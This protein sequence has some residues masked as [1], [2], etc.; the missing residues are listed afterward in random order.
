MRWQPCNLAI[1]EADPTTPGFQRAGY[2]GYPLKWRVNG[3]FDWTF[4]STSF[5]AN[6]QFFSRYHIDPMPD[7]CQC[8]CSRITRRGRR[9]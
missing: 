1:Q 9:G 4:G 8:F 2:F 6:L 3:G 7:Y 5:G